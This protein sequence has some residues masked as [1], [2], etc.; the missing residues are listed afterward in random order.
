MMNAL[1]LPSLP[2]QPPVVSAIVSTYNAERFMQGCLEDLVAQTLF[3]RMEVIIIDSGSPQNEAAICAP[4][5]QKYANIRYIRTERE[6]VYAAWN[7][8]VALATGTYLTNANTDDR[9]SPLAYETLS[10]LLD[11][12]PNAPLAYASQYSSRTENED[13]E[14]CQQ[15]GAE[16]IQ[17]T[18]QHF[19]DLI[20]RCS[21]GSQ[22]MWR[23][24][25]HDTY[26]LFN[27]DLSIV[28][29]WDFW[30]RVIQDGPLLN[31]GKVLGVLYESE[32]TVSGA[33]NLDRM[34]QQN[35]QVRKHHLAHSRCPRSR[36]LYKQ[37]SMALVGVGYH[38]ARRNQPANARAYF[39]EAWKL[40]PWSLQILRTWLLR[41]VLGLKVTR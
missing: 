36:D 7:R 34:E 6:G 39:Y 32:H 23:R 2:P 41:G 11:E 20:L 28:G 3:P 27:A 37:V 19:D 14:A 9:H 21:T 25:L 16:V 12:H 8:G 22:P 33:S 35:L 40:A 18:S 4:F 38:Y 30:L 1:P 29:D 31:A 13:F 15:R 17:W 5:V 24:S 26:G 10:R